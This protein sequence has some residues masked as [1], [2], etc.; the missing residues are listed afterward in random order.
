MNCFRQADRVV[1]SLMSDH[2]T[3][4]LLIET[5]TETDGR[6]LI[7]TLERAFHAMPAKGK[8]LPGQAIAT[9]FLEFCKNESLVL[10][11]D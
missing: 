2:T 8:S 1:D 7:E 3:A 9:F 5:T 11:P 6:Y 4:L 10:S